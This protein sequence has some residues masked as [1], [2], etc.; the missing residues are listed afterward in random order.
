MTRVCR[1]CV[2]SHWEA[3][4]PKLALE[5]DMD[6][7]DTFRRRERQLNVRSRKS[8]QRSA[9]GSEAESFV[10][11][12]SAIQKRRRATTDRG[13]KIPCGIFGTHESPFSIALA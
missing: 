8:N 10:R 7:Y 13:P 2:V 11:L 1:S 5:V 9:H 12:I 6:L 4:V 3:Y